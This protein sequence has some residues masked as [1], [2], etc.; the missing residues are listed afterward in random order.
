MLSMQIKN[1][2]VQN[3]RSRVLIHNDFHDTY[4]WINVEDGTV[5]SEDVD[6]LAQHL[7][8]MDDCCCHSVPCTHDSIVDV[9]G[10]YWEIVPEL[11]V[12]WR[13]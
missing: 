11:V 7:C 9:D 1:M 10:N 5:F 12:P 13:K 3:Q 8:G 6:S 2:K 4:G